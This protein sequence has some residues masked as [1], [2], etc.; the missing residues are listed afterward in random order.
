MAFSWQ[1][2][3]FLDRLRPRCRRRFRPTMCERLAHRDLSQHEDAAAPAAI[4]SSCVAVC[5][6]VLA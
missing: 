6:C 4:I 5:Q 3:V 2:F 1:E